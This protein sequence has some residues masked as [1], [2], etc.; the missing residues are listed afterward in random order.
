MSASR[1]TGVRQARLVGV[2]SVALFVLLVAI[3][4]VVLVV[5]NSAAMVV[6]PGLFTLQALVL[7][8]G[9]RRHPLR[10]RITWFAFLAGVC[11]LVAKSYSYGRW[12]VAVGSIPQSSSDVRKWNA[13]MVAATLANLACFIWG[14]AKGFRPLLHV[15]ATARAIR[16][17]LVGFAVVEAVTQWSWLGDR[18]T[19]RTAD[20]LAMVC[21]VG[22]SALIAAFALS[23]VTLRRLGRY[24][25]LTLVGAAGV[26]G[27]GQTV[28]LVA[29]AGVLPTPGRVFV[30]TLMATG[31]VALSALMPGMA[32]VGNPLSEFTDRPLTNVSPV[33]L[34]TITVADAALAGLAKGPWATS[35]VVFVMSVVV[36][37]QTVVIVWFSSLL[38]GIL[39]KLGHFRSRRLRKE[40]RG[41]VARCELE[42]HFQPIVRTSDMVVAGYETLARWQHPRLGLVTAHRFISIAASEGFLASIDHMMVRMAAEALPALFATTPVDHPFL[43]VNIEPKRMQQAG[44]ANR[45]L[46]D[47][48]ERRLDPKG[49]I[50]ELTET[51]AI[52]DW[53]ELRFN[54]ELFQQA[55]IGL[56][57]DDFGAG[58]SNFGLLVELDPDF[59]KLDQSLI[60]AALRS[61]R[62]RAVVRNAVQAAR[63]C[64]A[65]IVA[66]GVC[67]AD[68]AAPLKDLG[69]DHLQGYAFG[70]ACSADSYS[71]GR[72]A[73]RQLTDASRSGHSGAIRNVTE[74][75][76]TMLSDSERS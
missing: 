48:A 59:V 15:P 25:D 29:S 61:A 76:G 26:F 33:V 69:F 2:S 54:V 45:I 3:A 28:A 51:A 71:P 19:G 34:L 50:I 12:H 52:D 14:A 57:I 56:A 4:P 43:T 60:E 17:G 46:T 64:G 55:G 24:A 63:S 67:D 20:V 41:A 53:T 35:R 72:P 62:G 32:R 38:L 1:P 18:P 49:L 37:I 13:L 23:A 11:L 27:V 36:A 9:L 8:A 65:R 58:H 75:F 74:R 7:A 42:A 10:D 70:K 66:E 21:G 5:P 22:A 31:L 47:L 68:W 44:F 73:T 39:G 6:A 16:V 30:H 40:L